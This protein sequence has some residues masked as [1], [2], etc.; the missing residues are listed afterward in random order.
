MESLFAERN[1][2]FEARFSITFFDHFFRSRFRSLWQYGE[3]FFQSLL[4]INLLKSFFSINFFA[5]FFRSFFNVV[6]HVFQSLSSLSFLINFLRSHFSITFFNHFLDHF[7]E[8]LFLLLVLVCCNSRVLNLVST[9]FGGF[10]FS[11]GSLSLR[12]CHGVPCW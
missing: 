9:R 1:R 7:F 4:S 2:F 6:N 10:C 3:S 12:C 8:S 11:F 5:H